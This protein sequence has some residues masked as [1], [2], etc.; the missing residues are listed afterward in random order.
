LELLQALLKVSC[1]KLFILDLYPVKLDNFLVASSYNGEKFQK[2]SAPNRMSMALEL[3]KFPSVKVNP[4][5]IPQS[6]LSTNVAGIILVVLEST[7]QSI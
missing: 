1:L 2:T 7:E 4:T 6:L 5:G 3:L